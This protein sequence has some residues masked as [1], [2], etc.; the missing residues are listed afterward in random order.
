[1]RRTTL[2]TAAALLTATT[3]LVT[4]CASDE[5]TTDIEDPAADPAETMEDMETM[6]DDM[7]T[8]EPSDG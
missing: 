7:A 5:G 4:G 2:S 1:M 3:L 6:E 8:M